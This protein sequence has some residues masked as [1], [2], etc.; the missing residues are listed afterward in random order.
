MH[1][2]KRIS[3]YILYTYANVIFVMPGYNKYDD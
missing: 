1:L 3:I 2:Y